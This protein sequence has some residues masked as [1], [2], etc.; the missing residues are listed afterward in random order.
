MS[1]R[2]AVPL[3]S[4]SGLGVSATVAPFIWVGAVLPPP[5]ACAE[6][7]W[8]PAVLAEVAPP[9]SP[10]PP[11]LA[12]ERMTKVNKASN[13]T[14]L[15]SI[16]LLI[17]TVLPIIQTAL[18]TG[19]NQNTL[20]PEAAQPRVLYV[21]STLQIATRNL[22]FGGLPPAFASLP[23]SVRARFL[24]RDPAPCRKTN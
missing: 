24:L 22:L 18:G 2:V 16:A 9:P 14:A 19:P 7:V 21:L 17:P 5:V 13:G 23:P 12:N 10:P 6:V 3:T 11:Q 4:E 8:P 1:V 20:R 15:R